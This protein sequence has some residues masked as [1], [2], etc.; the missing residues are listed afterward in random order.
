[1]TKDVNSRFDC[2]CISTKIRQVLLY[3][4]YKVLEDDFL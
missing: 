4:G 3:Q 2:Y 1:M